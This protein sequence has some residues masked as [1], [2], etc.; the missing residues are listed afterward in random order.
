MEKGTVIRSK[1]R[2]SARNMALCGMMGALSA[3]LMLF[4]FPLPFMPPFLSF[5]FA[6][7]VEIIGGFVMGPMAAV[8]I[9]L[10]KILLQVITQGTSSM[11]TGEL[12]NFI[13]SC[14]YV[15]PAVLIYQKNKTKK[16]AV[17]GMVTG[18]VVCA[19]TAVFTN[20]FIIIP[21][22][23]ALFGMTMNDIITMCQAVNP[24]VKNAAGLA[25]LGIVPFNLIKNGILSLITYLIYKKISVH[26]KQFIGK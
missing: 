26:L 18:T 21:F 9:V 16:T 12:Q 25:V 15:L 2:F 7:I 17:T 3:I 11:W 8:A 19:I 6:G 20:L 1:S 24:F 22:Y 10:V 5:D 14:A 13:L 23:A 4:R